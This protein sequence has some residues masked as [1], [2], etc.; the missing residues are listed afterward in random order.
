MF[1][2]LRASISC[3]QP[4][5]ISTL[6]LLV[7]DSGQDLDPELKKIISKP[8]QEVRVLSSLKKHLG[9]CLRSSKF[10]MESMANFRLRSQM[11]FQTETMK[12]MGGK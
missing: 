12:C 1:R 2:A 6:F 7:K 3:H 10:Y 4:R 11:L 5:L 8:L 9:H